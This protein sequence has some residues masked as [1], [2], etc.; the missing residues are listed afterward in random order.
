MCFAVGCG[1]NGGEP[2]GTEEPVITGGIT[3]N[4]D[5]FLMSVGKSQQLYAFTADREIKVVWQSSAPEI[6]SVNGNGF[7]TANGVG[8][9]RITASY[10]D[11]F[12]VCEI[13]VVGEDYVPLLTLSKERLS[14][15]AGESV[16]V[17]ANVTLGGKTVD[18]AVNWSS[19]DQNV[20]T[21]NGGVIT[22][23]GGGTAII[24]ATAVSGTVTVS[25]KVQVKVVSGA[26][27][28]IRE[29]DV[30][31]AVTRITDEETE[32][33][34]STLYTDADGNPRTVS[35]TWSS[36]DENVVFVDTAGKITAVNAGVARITATCEENGVPLSAWT[37]VTAYK[38]RVPVTSNAGNTEVDGNDKISFALSK[39]DYAGEEGEEVKATIGKKV[40]FG[41]IAGNSVEIVTDGTVYGDSAMELEVADRIITAEIKITAKYVPFTANIS[42]WENGA[43]VLKKTEQTGVRYDVNLTEEL[44]SFG[45]DYVI[46]TGDSD[47]LIIS[48]DGDTVLNLCYKRGIPVAKTGGQAFFCAVSDKG[49]IGNAGV[50]IEKEDGEI[51]NYRNAYKVT[52]NARRTYIKIAGIDAQTAKQNGYSKL[53]FDLYYK[54]SPNVVGSHFNAANPAGLLFSFHASWEMSKEGV[55]EYV[56]LKNAAGGVAGAASSGIWTKVI[57]SLDT[58]LSTGKNV[59]TID[60]I[61]G[62]EADGS[63]YIHGATLEV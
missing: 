54:G 35:V 16:C 37:D 20:A 9:A 55:A 52:N 12:G 23:V 44:F 8:N 34:L 60:F 26:V 56:S 61:L 62:C 4:H 38:A 21:V 58:V 6:V 29:T 14:V 7:I 25:E 43:Y 33:D 19:S 1:K 63:F 3:L 57:I 22:G 51:G 30:A 59:K 50:S 10:G 31:I 2:T 13:T 36:S 24:T 18:A 40:F 17:T 45:T 15:Y 46:D 53:S 5:T 32:A 27:F 47:P 42:V 48:P 49:E 41:R 28:F 39:I 11:E